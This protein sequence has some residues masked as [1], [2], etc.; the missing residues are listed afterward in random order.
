M[1]ASESP[2]AV[3]N[4]PLSGRGGLMSRGFLGLLLTQFLGA[5]N[6]N[7]FRWLVVP[8]GK[9]YGGEG[10]EAE[11][12][13]IAA[14]CLML[15]YLLFA[16][17]AGF[18]ADRFSKR[19]VI[20]CLKLAEL[21]LMIVGVLAVSVATPGTYYILYG[22]VFLIG[23][24]S[25]LFAPSKLG[26]I[27]EIVRSNKISAANGV[28]GLTTI[29]G[30]VLGSIAGPYIY[31]KTGEFGQGN[32]WLTA[33][34]FL[35]VALSGC[36]ASLLI[37]PLV[38][39]DRNR[40]FPRNPL[41]DTWRDLML[42]AQNRTLLRVVLGIV[43]FWSLA[44]LANLNIDA[45]GSKVLLLEQ[46]E[47]GPLLG[48]LAVGV[49]LGSALAGFL[50]SGRVELG[51]VPLGAAGVALSAIS[52][53]IAGESY[54]ATCFWLF[55]LGAFAGTF[56]IPLEAYVQ[57][58]SPPQHRG[59]ILAAS[60][61]LTFSGMLLFTGLFFLLQAPLLSDGA[62]LMS[63]RG[64]FLL[65]G[66]CTVPVLLYTLVLLPQ[67]TIRMIVWIFSLLIYRVRVVGRENLPETG[68]ALLIPNHVSWIDGVLLLLTS[69]R[70][71]R[72][73]VY[74]DYIEGWWIRGLARLMGAIPIK[75]GG[76][77][78]VEALRTAR[79]ALQNGELVCIFPEGGLTRT[80]QLMAFR[81]GYLRII[82]KTDAPVIPVYLD[83]LFGS[84]FS[85]Y[86][87]KVFWK[88]PRRWPY[89]VSIVFGHP[90]AD[91]DDT[92]RLR[93]AVQDLGVTAV[94][95]R[96]NQQ[97][98]LPRAML[99]NLRRSKFR[100]K[101][102]DTMGTELKGGEILL[103]TL[104]L[105]RI[106]LREILTPDEK[107]V[108]LLLPP[109]AAGVLANAALPLCGRIGV[110]LNY[111]VSAEVMAS[112]I[113]QCGIKHVLTSRRMMK[114][115]DMQI[116]AEL[117][118]LEDF[119]DKVQRSD[120][121]VA[122]AQAYAM[123][124]WM[125][126]RLLGL[127]KIKTDDVLT[128]VFTSGSTGDPKGVMLTYGNVASNIDAIDQL[129]QLSKTD[130]LAGVLPF[131]HSFGYTATL[132]TVLSLEPKGAY[133]FSPLDAKLIG[134]MCNAQ[135]ATIMIATP[136]FLR[137]Y[138]K[139]CQPEDF[140][141]MDV[142]ITGAE[143][144][145]VDLCNAYEEKFGVRPAEGYGCTELSPLVAVNVPAS[146]TTTTEQLLLKEGTVGRPVPGVS[147]KIEHPETGVELGVDQPGLLWIK[148][149]NV[150]KGYLHHPEMTAKVI[151]DGWYN[152]GDIALI[153][154]DGFIKITGRESRFSKIGGEMVP[155]IKIEET[156]QQIVAEGDDDQELRAVVTAVPDE[157]RGER[158]V[159]MHTKL[160]KTPDEICKA[161]SEAGLPNLWIPSADSFCEVP[162]I[163]ILGTGKL[164][165]KGLKNLALEKCTT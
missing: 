15:P 150:M 50:S 102:A 46:K 43:F 144:L 31:S 26:S 74:A 126:E 80:G 154:A 8:I 128:I 93:R 54:G 109:S 146:R 81:P 10:H 99:R 139:R 101:V 20:V 55:A 163:P 11:A 51:L 45:H 116:D 39:A 114:K 82:E 35:G 16:S 131:F 106:L 134:S 132:W 157:R 156:L 14:A 23:I 98:N 151:R 90:V 21:A 65:A 3:S 56:D 19:S 42:L 22:M 105:R 88:W 100:P 79:K 124:I 159:V 27:P 13:T 130:V 61:F 67:A 95:E 89:R 136:T 107:Y 83:G 24:Q 145:P 58:R 141:A 87:G 6:V 38:A 149:P 48:I 28:I 91:R 94:A 18:L 140:A 1:T 29:V 40:A 133:H 115:I 63:P 4:S 160:T 7:M 72:M 117:V 25:A 148:G 113:K 85:Y 108:G 59:A 77:S 155:H 12:L 57:H 34:P 78:T 119:K 69:S 138:M 161:L 73:I 53:F 96:Q 97:L 121:I 66:L 70:P 92:F 104:I 118:Y 125:L 32:P 52:L 137:T 152:T 129:V 111:T 127:T 17:H 47:I 103:R 2:D 64:I 49:G 84:I 76:R 68:G 142:V 110:N 60:N 123:P 33:L 44:S 41:K 135:R 75:P 5:V 120:K 30:I 153:D 112:C 71:I 36:L 9:D 62:S 164:D 162:E 165:L 147:A 37:G 143:R 86:G 158:L 122:A